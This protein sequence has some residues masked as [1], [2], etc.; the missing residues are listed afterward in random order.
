M[1]AAAARGGGWTLVFLG[2][3]PVGILLIRRVLGLLYSLYKTKDPA[4]NPYIAGL[5]GLINLN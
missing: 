1:K 5:I 3:T 2:S 4:P